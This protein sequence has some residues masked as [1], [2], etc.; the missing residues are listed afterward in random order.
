MNGTSCS[1][2]QNV[3]DGIV[4]IRSNNLFEF[5]FRYIEFGDMVKNMTIREVEVVLDD[6]INHYKQ[7]GVRID[8]DIRVTWCGKQV[9]S[10]ATKTREI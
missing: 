6:G 10:L 8:A 1:C 5:P 3:D 9:R 4:L 2:C 7:D